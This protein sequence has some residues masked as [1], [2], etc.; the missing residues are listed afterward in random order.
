[1]RSI[2]K[3]DDVSSWLKKLKD[4][5]VNSLGFDTELSLVRYGHHHMTL[6]QAHGGDIINNKW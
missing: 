5:S 2:V 4:A 6:K 1:M 3:E